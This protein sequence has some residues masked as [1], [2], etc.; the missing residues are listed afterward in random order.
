MVLMDMQAGTSVSA[1]HKES[2]TGIKDGSMP[3]RDRGIVQLKQL[4][5]KLLSPMSGKW[6]LLRLSSGPP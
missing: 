6:A 2:S 1:E 5:L 4:K 3:R